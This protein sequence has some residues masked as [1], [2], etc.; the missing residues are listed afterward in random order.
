MAAVAPVIAFNHTIAL[1]SSFGVDQTTLGPQFRARS[2][3]ESERSRL[4]DRR[5]AYYS[6]SQHDWKQYDF[7]G[8]LIQQGNPLLGQPLLMSE[9][10][11]WYV[12]LKT[13]RPSAPYRLPRAIV[14]AFTNLIFGYQR[15]PT[16]RCPGDPDTEE[17]VRAVVEVTKLR[18]LMV[19]AR[20]L[21]GSCGT[22]GLSWRISKGV[23]RIR[24]HA[25]KHIYV[26]A[27]ADRELLMPGHVTEIYRFPR[28]EWDDQKKQFTRNWYWFRHDWTPVA[29]VAF[30]E[31]KAD[32]GVDP[33]WIIDEENSYRHDDG[34]CHFVWVQNL[35]TDSED[36]DGVPDYEGLY[37][38]FDALDLLNSVLVRG[39]TLNLDPTLILKLDP[40]I[41]ALHGI[42]KGS[43]NSLSVGLAGD[44]RYME[45]QGSSV[46]V[47]TT[48]FTKMREAALEV[49]QCIIPDPN[50]IGA[51]GT[52]SVALKVV[53]APMLGKADVLREQYEGAMRTLLT[54]ITISARRQMD[55]PPVV[56]TDDEGNETEMEP[57]IELPPRM[58]TVDVLDEQGNPTGEKQERAVPVR[59]GPSSRLVFDW[60]DYFL[61]TPSDQQQTASTLSAMVTGNLLSQES[62]ADL[63]SRVVR[64]DPRADWALLQK[65]KAQ[66]AAEQ[67]QA[68]GAPPDA[69]GGMGGAVGNQDELPPGALPRSGFGRDGGGADTKELSKAA[70]GT[71]TV[72]EARSAMGERP[73]GGE[74]GGL[75][76]AEFG[77]RT[78]AG[79]RIAV[80]SAKA[81]IAAAREAPKDE[82]PFGR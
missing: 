11:N 25:A 80:E 9:P 14:D 32:P 43:D 31:I 20:A 1:A 18:T 26:H 67:A 17:F 76:L 78:R 60:G 63:A 57:T 21:G 12:P 45:L 48:L 4:L 50:Q 46:Q 34:F 51:A 39:T 19:R 53:Y 24:V 15:W 8:R 37:E 55:G 58:V 16:V 28:D 81:E 79:E 3:A 59:P 49:A 7:D 69:F 5:Q 54:Q 62:G 22:T 56:L 27:W 6:C 71:L 52:S 77:A 13:R 72:D 74:L 41:V 42:K 44:A 30:R 23:P 64:I 47:G 40:E 75:T 70:L 36:I 68:Q 29:D 61:P 10:S 35:P 65:E 66:K 73:L 38:N 33:A 82:P 2:I